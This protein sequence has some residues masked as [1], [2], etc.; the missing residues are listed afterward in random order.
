MKI[1]LFTLGFL[2]IIASIGIAGCSNIAG[3]SSVVTVSD[4]T[5]YSQGITQAEQNCISNTQRGDS[6][7][8]CTL[9][10][11]DKQ[12]VISYVTTTVNDK[13][14]EC[15]KTLIKS[16]DASICSLTS[17]EKKDYTASVAHCYMVDDRTLLKWCIQN[18]DF[19]FTQ[20]QINKQP[21]AG[22][23]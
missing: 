3:V 11:S 1:G 23:I 18:T 13:Q 17:D 20:S 12:S 6:T 21:V 5:L 19:A 14:Q 16:Q 22:K 7:S 10:S 8:R 15:V 4:D 2:L 9:S